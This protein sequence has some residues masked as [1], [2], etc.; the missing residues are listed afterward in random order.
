MALRI[1]A[2]MIEPPFLIDEKGRPPL[3]QDGFIAL[4]NG[5]VAPRISAP[6]LRP[7]EEWGSPQIP[8][9]RNPTRPDRILA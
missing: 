1:K 8:A 5:F 4:Q 9:A 3:F 7:P 2:N 6:A